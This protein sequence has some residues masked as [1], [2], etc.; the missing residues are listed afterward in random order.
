ML[1]TRFRRLLLSLFLGAAALPAFAQTVAPPTREEIERGRIEQV[2]R[3]RSSNVTVID[4]VER[5]PCPL[6]DPRYADIG[7]TV[8][9]VQFA[10]LAPLSAEI[11]RP[12]WADYAGRTVPVST[13][14]EIR[15]RAATILRRE[16]YL[17]AVQVP[18]QRIEADGV[19]RFDV[20]LAKLVRV[21]VRGDA[22]RAEGAIESQLRALQE[23]PVFNTHEAERYLLLAQDMPGYDIRLTLRSAG[24]VPGEVLGE[25]TVSYT[26]VEIDAAIQNFGSRSVGRFGGLVRAQFNGLTGMGDST[27]LSWFGTS[28][29]KEQHVLQASHSFLAGGEGLRLGGDFTYAWTRPSIGAGADLR[30]NTLVVTLRATYPFLR[31]QSANAYGTLGLDVIDQDVKFIGVPVSRDRLRVIFARLDYDSFDLA[32]ASSTAG[33]AAAEPRWRFAGT[34]EAR[35]G[36]SFL[37]ASKPCGP[38]FLRCIPPNVGLSKAEADPTALVL[39]ASA[40]AEY[41]PRPR[42]AVSIAPRVQWASGPLLN[43]EE[44]SAGNYTVGR[45]YDPGA[46]VG[47]RGI[48]VQ[49][50]VKIGSLLPRGQNAAAIQPFGFFDAAWIWNDDRLFPPYPRNPERLYSAGAGVRAA[51][52]HH[53]RLEAYAAVPLTRIANQTGRG[54]IRF[55][56]SLTVKLLPWSL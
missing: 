39:R 30:A 33:Y 34:L 1:L 52:A 42:L 8:S 28:D 25:V 9:D 50:E 44:F 31:S 49:A 27:V 36:L 37:G 18:P 4:Q 51:W 56:V 53:A 13:V 7:F 35:Q 17:A 19:V 15:D 24:T 11:L 47:D 21:Q 23:R 45:G 55:L 2:D 38:A 16:G 14:C 10:N 40:L 5:A 32:S 48:G 26:P 20:L 46:L 6:A 12:A 43:Y 41:R 54:D 22:G 3:A 29:F